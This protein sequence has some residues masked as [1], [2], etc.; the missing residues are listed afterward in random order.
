MNIFFVDVMD[1]PLLYDKQKEL[2]K[3]TVISERPKNKYRGKCKNVINEDHHIQTVLQVKCDEDIRVIYE[4]TSSSSS[5]ESGMSVTT[6]G[7]EC[8]DKRISE[9][10]YILEKDES[11]WVD[12]LPVTEAVNTS[13]S[14]SHI[15][16]Y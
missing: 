2:N 5:C 16:I 6:N 12:S 11:P 14:N 3:N 8:S 9:I 4:V 13:N 7:N 15:Y 10:V 1:C